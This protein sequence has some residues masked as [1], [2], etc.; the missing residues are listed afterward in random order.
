MRWLAHLEPGR[1][2][3]LL[4]CQI[5]QDFQEAGRFWSE[6]RLGVVLRPSGL[7]LT[8]ALLGQDPG[9]L[10]LDGDV[11]KPLQH[12]R[13]RSIS[14]IPTSSQPAILVVP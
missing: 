4:S 8:C 5:L 12:L 2:E 9:F 14:C 13:L 3:S 11:R 1:T 10:G 7:R 6:K